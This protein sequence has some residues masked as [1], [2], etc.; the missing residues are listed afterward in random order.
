MIRILSAS[1]LC[2]A[3]AV[4]TLS[5]AADLK[6]GVI[7]IARVMEESPQ[8]DAARGVMEREVTDKERQLRESQSDIKAQ[9]ERLARDGTI[10]S[11]SERDRVE[12]DLFT[13]RRD[14]KR[15]QDT[16]R[17]E[18]E[19]R[20]G[21]VLNGLQKNISAVLREFAKDEKFDLLLGDGVVFVSEKLDV[22]E[23]VLA[24]LK[25]DYDKPKK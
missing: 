2:C 6:I 9:E 4:P 17:D 7:N 5:A 1:L 21:E 8:A 11:A 13:K 23:Q 24:R 25:K 14:V 18:L 15:Q 16:L 19:F 3:L 10:M 22:T 20:R 12:K